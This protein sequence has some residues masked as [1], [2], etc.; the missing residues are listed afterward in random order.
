MTNQCLQ[1]RCLCLNV[2]YFLTQRD[3]QHLTKTVL[4][5]KHSRIRVAIMNRLDVFKANFTNVE[6]EKRVFYSWVKCEGFALGFVVTNVYFLLQW[7]CQDTAN[8]G[9]FSNC[10]TPSDLPSCLYELG[11]IFMLNTVGTNLLY[12][13]TY[14][15]GT[16][17][18]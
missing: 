5:T 16:K 7:F 18:Q 1:L 14:L 17:I 12:F 15:T 6:S 13:L 9:L 10:G 11:F 8:I 2:R 3:L 4:T